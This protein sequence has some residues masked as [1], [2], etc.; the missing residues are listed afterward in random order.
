MAIG[1]ELG[2]VVPI[3]VVN[4]VNV[5]SGQLYSSFPFMQSTFPSQAH[6]NGI[7]VVALHA[8]SPG[9]LLSGM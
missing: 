3:V 9:Q 4:G 5:V 2:V 1:D 8:N 7:H 6:R